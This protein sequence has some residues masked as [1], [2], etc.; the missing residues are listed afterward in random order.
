MKYLFSSLLLFAL[1]SLSAQDANIVDQYNSVEQL[2][3]STWQVRSF[4]VNEYSIVY[5]DQEYTYRDTVVVPDATTLLDSAG[6]IRYLTISTTN[7]QGQQAAVTAR[8]FQT[9]ATHRS[10]TDANTLINQISGGTSNFSEEASKLWADQITGTYR[11][12]VDSSG[13]DINF[14]AKVELISNGAHPDGR[15]MRLSR[16]ET[17]ACD[18]LTTFWNFSPYHRWKWAIPNFFGGTRFFVW[19]RRNI[20]RPVY[21]D[22]RFS[23]RLTVNRFVKLQ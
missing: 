2:N 12:F 19:D 7:E 18:S 4:Q 9:Y 5:Q 20:E 22:D 3:D 13:T 6:I 8:A 17:A 10:V 11:V 14:F 1:C 16:C 23:T 15:I 21:I